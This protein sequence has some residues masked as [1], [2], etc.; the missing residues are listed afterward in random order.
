VR[1]VRRFH[2]L[3]A[4]AGIAILLAGCGGAMQPTPLQRWGTVTQAMQRVAAGG[5]SWISPAAKASKLLYIARFSYHDV[6]IYDSRTLKLIGALSGL[7]NPQG[8]ALDKQRNVYV[9]DQGPNVVS[10]FHR[11]K[12]APFETLTDHDGYLLQVVVGNDGTVYV[13]DE[14]NFSL[15]NGNVIEYAPGATTPSRRIDDRHF[16]VVEDVGLDSHNNLYV[17]F[18][19][20]HVVGRVNEY[21]PGSTQGKRLPMSLRGVGGIAFD[22]ADDLQ[23]VDT[24]AHAVKVFAQGSSSPKYEFAQNQIDPWDVALARHAIRAY[25]T[26]PYT[27]NTYEYALP[28]GKQ[29]HVIP[30]PSGTS[31]VAVEQ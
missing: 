2:H 3:P 29:L 27:G 21:P 30:N 12:T 6:Q 31:G 25:V 23:V 5:Q 9:V 22:T 26:D 15:G 11:G 16:N 18:F 4:V 10:V 1:H 14:Y 17:T 28:S 20:E 7:T 13:T 24:I 8:V 19:D